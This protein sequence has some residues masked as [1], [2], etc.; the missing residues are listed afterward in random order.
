MIRSS[1]SDRGAPQ[2]GDEADIS[3]GH[4]LG[5][6]GSLRHIRRGD[7]IDGRFRVDRFAGAGGMG[8]VF[9]ALD[10]AT[11]QVVALKMLH[12]DDAGVAQRFRQEATVL[13]G[14]SHPG[15]VRY[16]ADGRSET[17][18]LYLAM[19]WLDGEDLVTR[20]ERQGLTIAE[21]VALI[22]RVADALGSAHARGVVHRDVTPANLFLVGGMVE[23][24][25]VLD[26][27]IARLRDAPRA[28][29]ATGMLM[30]TPAYMA[31]EQARGDHD[32]DARAD[33]YA[34]G[35]VLFECLTGRSPF[36]AETLIGLLAKVLLDEPPHVRELRPEVPPELDAL[37]AQMLAKEAQHRPRD[38]R[39]IAAELAA[40]GH[41]DQLARA[42][43]SAPPPAALTGREQRLL[44]VILAGAVA[45]LPEAPVSLARTL[46]PEE[47]T[48][49]LERLRT[50]LSRFGAR[51]ETLLDGSLVITLSGAIAATDQAQRAARCALSLRELLP[52]APMALATGRG[53]M[54][55]RWPVGEVIDR[56]AALL[57]AARDAGPDGTAHVR[58]DE[59]T[60]GLL[61]ARF[62]VGG[63]A[64]GLEL[65]GEAELME[66]TRTVLGKPTPC[67][68]RA[69][70]L[71]DLLALL[72]RCAGESCAQAVILSG[73]PGMGKTRVARELVELVRRGREVEVWTARGDA[74]AAGSP[75]GLLGGAVRRAA[76]IQDGEAIEVQQQKLRARIGRCVAGDAAARVAEFLGELCG[77]PFPDVD[78]VELRVARRDPV[79]LGD[80][81]A[82]AFQDL[83]EAE[84]AVQPVVLVLEDLHWGDLP[85]L[86]LL[87]GALRRHAELPWMVLGLAR[88]EIDETFPK[89]WSERNVQRIRLGELTRGA[90]AKLVREVLGHVEP[91][92]SEWLVDRAG[93][94][95]FYLEELIRTAAVAASSGRAARP[96]TGEGLPG[97]VLAMV[98]SRVEGLETEARRLLRAASVFGQVF[99]AGGVR[100]LL[101]GSDRTTRGG[102]WLDELVKREL[103]ERRRQSK[104]PGDY[105]YAFRHGLVRDAAYATLT[106]ADRALGH[107]LA[108][109]WLED[110]GEHDA[111]LLA[112]HFERGNEPARAAGWY[113]RAAQQAVGGSD[114][115]AALRRADRAIACLSSIVQRSATTEPPV[116][117][118]G[119]RMRAVQRSTVPPDAGSPGARVPRT[120]PEGESPAAPQVQSARPEHVI[121]AL[122]LLQ[123]EVH[124]W[125]GELV[126]AEER[127]RQAIGLLPAESDAWFSACGELAAAC[128]RLGN[129][130]ELERLAIELS[131][132]TAGRRVGAA[133][134]VAAARA[135]V[136][137]FVAGKNELGDALLDELDAL[138]PDVYRREPA[139]HARVLG[140]RAWRAVTSGDTGSYRELEE[141][142]AA[143]YQRAGH[144]RNACLAQVNAGYACLEIGDHAEAER[145]IR[146]ALEAATRMNVAPVAALARH[147]LGVA[148]ARR[149]ALD[150]AR[151]LEQEARDA[152]VAQGNRRLEV[153]ARVALGRI[154]LAGGELDRAERELRAGAERA[155][156]LPGMRVYALAAVAELCLARGAAAEA[157]VAARESNQ[158][159]ESSGGIEDGEALA[160]RVLAEALDACGEHAAAR[161]A[162]AAAARR[163]HERAERMADPEWRRGFLER[164]PDNARTMQ[165]HRTWSARRSS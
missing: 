139:A 152:F 158:L 137:L 69:R 79:L 114:L 90:A 24:V 12:A 136:G 7:V 94:N 140:A 40:L 6:R 31:P 17:G 95:A 118:S 63:D 52:E 148:L 47:V 53:V 119:F 3:V 85:S 100:Q 80:Q 37:V 33:V 67:V 98:Q 51:V 61:D 14:V 76:G 107:R 57:E 116:R 45:E 135:A 104:F 133:Q 30:G 74:L 150:E 81:M 75:F 109:R 27:G 4:T 124:S 132:R 86:R 122:R 1:R 25:K 113:H 103:I 141:A 8:Q 156:R 130:D 73:A 101:G 143:S 138:D 160:R 84:C 19:E 111:A 145:S 149:G 162:I 66:T 123:A 41:L 15:V 55:A 48:G 49:E 115:D 56:A 96:A 159:L 131:V 35:A 93:G 127:A 32:V 165:L 9:R 128:G 164:V 125:R 68:G 64:R 120:L 121:G 16:V 106:D 146:A 62:D 26:F 59:V 36:S 43:P 2:L 92:V 60:A 105:E 23:E 54:G 34:L 50:A 153:A 134:I 10:L 144:H 126:I 157:L 142:A 77:V 46:T 42:D 22:S 155:E 102:G 163:L 151:A 88:P 71:A 18:Q 82:R 110:A 65:R 72:D 38:A 112:Q 108:G 44:C 5:P 39:A 129:L 78:S 83:V 13:A 91:H 87:D 161:R 97:T 58:L 11:G 99:W 154:E 21:S 20:L 147:N 28:A 29:T 117:E 89:L 70:E